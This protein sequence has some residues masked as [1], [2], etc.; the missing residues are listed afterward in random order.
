MYEEIAEHMSS[1][2]I[3]CGGASLHVKV[4]IPVGVQS[5]FDY[6]RSVGLFC[7]DSNYCK[8]VR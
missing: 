7:V 5:L 1:S 3:R 6:A 2:I 4:L 8:G